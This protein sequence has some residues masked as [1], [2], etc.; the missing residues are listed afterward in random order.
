ML[1]GKL[2]VHMREESTS[3]YV[4][5]CT[6]I[7][8]QPVWVLPEKAV[9][10][11]ISRGTLDCVELREAC[12][13]RQTE[14]PSDECSLLTRHEWNIHPHTKRD[15]IAGSDKCKTVSESNGVNWTKRE[16]NPS[17]VVKGMNTK[18]GTAYRKHQLYRQ[19]TNE[20]DRHQHQ[21]EQREQATRNQA[22]QTI[23]QRTVASVHRHTS[24]ERMY[25]MNN[26]VANWQSQPQ[27]AKS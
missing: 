16:A 14:V 23:T 7:S 8:L 11:K 26:T 1:D 22:D 3:T 25:Q 17:E 9:S 27:P 20:K 10:F 15:E 24:T 4:T 6:G 5:S 12:G 18:R 19:G 21:A 2:E 13:I